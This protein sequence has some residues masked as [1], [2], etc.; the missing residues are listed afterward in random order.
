MSLWIYLFWTFHINEMEFYFLW[1]FVM[2]KTRL[3]CTGTRLNLRDRALGK[4]EKNSCIVSPGKGDQSGFVPQKLCPNPGGFGGE[5]YFRAS[6]WVPV[7]AGLQAFNLVSGDLMSFSEVENADIFHLL[8][9]LVLQKSSEILL[10]ASLGGNQ[11]PAPRPH[12][13]FLAAL[14]SLMS[15]CLILTFGAQNHGG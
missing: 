11:G 5:F 1:P 13:C 9:V 8:G 14:P 12:C 4:V 2:P 7:C 10:H 6:G 15:S 3:W